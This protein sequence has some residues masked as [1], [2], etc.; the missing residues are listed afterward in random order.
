MSWCAS[1]KLWFCRERPYPSWQATTGT[2]SWPSISRDAIPASPGPQAF[3][4][5]LIQPFVFLGITDQI[6]LDSRWS[7]SLSSLPVSAVAPIFCASQ[8]SRLRRTT[9]RHLSIRRLV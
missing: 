2:M 1:G 7:A 4:N 3:P 8:I 9:K 5:S 6:G